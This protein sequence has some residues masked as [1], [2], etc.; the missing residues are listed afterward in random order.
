M[1]YKKHTT[2][3]V[4]MLSVIAGVHLHA[5]EPINV[6]SD[7]QLF[8]DD[9]FF[10]TSKDV[11]LKIQP[12]RKTGEVILR[13]EHRWESATL[14]W[15]NVVQDEGRID[16]IAKYRMWYE[17]Y[18]VDGWPTA[19]DTSFCYAESRNGI[20]WTKP[21]LGLFTYNGNKRNNILFRQ[22]GSQHH[23]NRSRVHGTGVFIDANG[24]SDRRY[25][26][27]GQGIFGG[28]EKPPHRI[29]GMYSADGLKWSRLSQ[30]ICDVFADSQYSGFW[31]SSR[32]KYVLY[33]RVGGRG[34][35]LGRSESDQFAHFDGLK[36]IMEADEED[37]PQSDLYNSAVVKYPYAPN[38]YLMFPSLYQHNPDTLDIRLA[39]SRDGVRWSR[40]DRQTPF[41]ALGKRNE[42]DTGSLYM[43]QGMIRVKDEL[44]LYYSASP[45]RH[46]GAELETLTKPQ[47]GRTYRRAV[48]QL[49]RFV[50]AVPG[51]EGGFFVTPPLRFSGH[52][53][54]LNVNVQDG[55]SVRIGLLNKDGQPLPGRSVDD[56]LPIIGDSL[57]VPVEWRS[58]RDVSLRGNKSTRIRVEATGAELFGFQFV[59]SDPNGRQP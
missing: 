2:A 7:K 59:D 58:G 4:T 34:R 16:A 36:L 51:P 45:L 40:P 29:A 8:L 10:A 33:G 22:I 17:A 56:C 1:K 19:D 11:T 52:T 39:V 14:N 55:G 23:G 38:V 9:L 53:L 50:A 57:S 15:F 18:D 32:G 48:T 24:P 54:K 27:V 43:G 41:I 21:E 12:P 44:W 28:R 25:K 20:Q 30:P 26:A 3:I 5:Q 49:D 42:F 37:P 46:N 35:S 6:G 31:D 13:R 47:N